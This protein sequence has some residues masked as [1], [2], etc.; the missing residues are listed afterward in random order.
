VKFFFQPEPHS[1]DTIKALWKLEKIVLDTLNFDEVVQ[2]IVDSVLV[3]LGYL[4]L[5]YRIIVL[6]LHNPELSILKRISLSQTPEAAQ[7]LATTKIPFPQMDISMNASNNLCVRCFNTQIP[8]YTEYWPDI[9][10]PP[11]AKED[12]LYYQRL[13]GIKTSMVYPVIAKGKTLGVLIFSMTKPVSKVTDE[14][15]DLISSFTSVVGI[16]VQNAKL[17]SDLENTTKALNIANEN[18]KIANIKLQELD[19]LKD[20]FVSL[21]SHEL[22]A[23]MTVIKG[24]LSTILDGYA[25]ETSKEA[26]EFLTAA[27][28]ENDRLI[29]LVNNLLNISRIESGRLKFLVT[30][31]DMSKLMKDVVTNL[32]M[33]AKEKSLRLIIDKLDQLPFVLADEDKVREVLIN[34]IGNAIKFTHQG[35]ITVSA[36]VEKDMLITSVADTGNGIAPEDQELLFKKFS[37]VSRGTYS[38]QTGGTGLGLYISKK[39]IE[40][41][42]GQ[43]WLTSTVGKGTTFYFSLPVVK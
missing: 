35:G 13:V 11:F 20:E 17:Y 27:Y 9:L 41:L 26:K 37:Q 36:K 29:R 32:Q 34:L 3:E 1:Q 6:I 38:R 2:R 25:G 10:T 5:G 30:N 40:G 31:V 23:P 24:S 7:L 19:K 43:I 16:A 28:S 14:E 18:L 21:A 42:H 39:I 4:N 12:A 8:T 15:R 33:A 22:R